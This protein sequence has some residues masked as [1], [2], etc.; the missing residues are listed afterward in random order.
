MENNLELLENWKNSLLVNGERNALFV[1]SGGSTYTFL[2]RRGDHNGRD[3][4][5]FVVVKRLRLIM[6]AC[7]FTAVER[8]S[9][10]VLIPIIP[11]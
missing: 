2:D 9:R 3:S 8:R 11:Q 5:G 4:I 7:T 1:E 10:I 6:A